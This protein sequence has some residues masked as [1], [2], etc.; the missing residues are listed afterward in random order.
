MVPKVSRPEVRKNKTVAQILE[1]FLGRQAV[2]DCHQHGLSVLSPDGE[3]LVAGIT[4]A[5]MPE[6][7]TA[8]AGSTDTLVMASTAATDAPAAATN[9]FTKQQQSSYIMKPM[10]MEDGTIAYMYDL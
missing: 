5:T 2:G 10:R 9:N 1:E 8:G 4:A 3:S 7:F 6:A